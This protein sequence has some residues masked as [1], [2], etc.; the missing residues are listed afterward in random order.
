MFWLLSSFHCTLCLV[1]H[2]AT[3]QTDWTGSSLTEHADSRPC[4][5]LAHGE[6]ICECFSRQHSFV[7]CSDFSPGTILSVISIHI[8]KVSLSLAGFKDELMTQVWLTKALG[9]FMH[10]FGILASVPK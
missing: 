1:P 8:V 6:D 3:L 2:A 9:S 5:F 10:W 7:M 4:T